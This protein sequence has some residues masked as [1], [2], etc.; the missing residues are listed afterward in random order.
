MA[1]YA[2]SRFGFTNP[3]ASP[4][5]GGVS[6]DPAEIERGKRQLLT[7]IMGAAQMGTFNLSDE[8][9]GYAEG[10][11]GA[12]QGKPFWETVDKATERLRGIEKAGAEE[13]P[14]AYSLGSL[15]G[16]ALPVG[17]AKIGGL[18][19][20]LAPLLKGRKAATRLAG[21]AAEGG[22][23]GALYNALAGYGGGEGGAEE[24]LKEVPAAAKEGGAIGFI[25]GGAPGLTRAARKAIDAWKRGGKVPPGLAHLFERPTEL[26]RIARGEHE[27]LREADVGGQ[28][29]QQSFQAEVPA[30]VK[31]AAKM[32][33]WGNTPEHIAKETGLER[34][35][36]GKWVPAL[37]GSLAR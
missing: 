7:A 10:A 6:T 11:V 35:H 31:L 23:Y 28:R 9:G 16:I 32:E 30:E 26:T 27:P 1:D 24:R 22:V 29:F 3:L 21:R 12:L 33:E 25:L 19:K 4:D 2:K 14:E 13:N 20:L 34:D 36:T 5:E 37:T 15:A 17:F 18:E 8:L